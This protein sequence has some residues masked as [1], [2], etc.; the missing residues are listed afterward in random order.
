MV[1]ASLGEGAG[2]PAVS[3]DGKRL[4]FSRLSPGGTVWSAGTEPA[5]PRP[6][7]VTA[8]AETD[9]TPAFSPDGSEIA[10]GSSR[11]GS[12]E[13]WVCGR[14]GGAARQL[15]NYNGPGTGSPRW[16]PDGKWIVYDSR[17]E[18]QPDI[19]AIPS[20]GG[21][22]VRLTNDPAADVSPSWSPD[23][24]WIYFCSGRSGGRQ[25]W[26]MPAG[27]GAAEQITRFGGCHPR[28]SADGKTL[29]Y[30]K[31]AGVPVTSVWKVPAEGGEELLVVNN[32]LDRCF[33]LYGRRIYYA[34]RQPGEPFASQYYRGLSSNKAGLIRRLSEA[35]SS[36]IEISPDGAAMH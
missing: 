23:G 2:F 35:L 9:A 12:S 22:P 29:Y 15:T 8:S 21:A 27:G 19:Y 4:V 31:Q 24:R 20:A 18:G 7:K 6:S 1:L 3:P 17:I 16:S 14:N 10:F 26:R 5:G 28:L 33:A 34:A 36:G 30:M 11:S 32:V 25:V 13:I